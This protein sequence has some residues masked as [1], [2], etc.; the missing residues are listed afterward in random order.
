MNCKK[1]KEHLFDKR[2]HDKIESVEI[3]RGLVPRENWIIT[4]IKYI[5]CTIT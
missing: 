2:N 1:G 4:D 5:F 3:R